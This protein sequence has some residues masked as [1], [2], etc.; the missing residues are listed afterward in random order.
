MR[1][2][3]QGQEALMEWVQ[4]HPGVWVCTSRL[5]KRDAIKS[6]RV[7]SWSQSFRDGLAETGAVSPYLEARADVS[8]P[9]ST[10]GLTS[11]AAKTSSVALLCWLGS[12]WREEVTETEVILPFL[13]QQSGF[14]QLENISLLKHSYKNTGCSS[15]LYLGSSN[16]EC[17]EKTR[18]G[19]IF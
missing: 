4:P 6:S 5:C 9:T 2:H 10:G 19:G 14:S 1:Q 8:T 7:K 18:P 17:S 12:T 11:L 15:Q 16:K 13:R 3:R